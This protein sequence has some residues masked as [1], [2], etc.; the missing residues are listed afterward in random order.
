M[1]GSIQGKSMIPAIFKKTLSGVVI[2]SAI[3]VSG[4]VNAKQ[5]D[6]IVVGAGL[7]GLTAA[8]ELEQR[9]YNVVIL[10]AR[11]RVGGRMGTLDMG[12]QHGETGGELLD[13]K[14]VHTEMF[15]YAKK[16]K[17]EMVDVGYWENG[18]EEG[19]YYIDGK[20]I[21]YGDFK[22]E[23]GRPVKREMDRFWNAVEDLSLL[24]PDHTRPDLAPD[25]QILDQM[26]MQDWINDL[27]LHPTAKK[28]AE[29]HVRAEYD[30]PHDVSVL[31]MAHQSKVYENVGDNKIEVIRFMEGGRAFAQAYVDHIDGPVLLNHAVTKIRQND[32]GVVV[33]ASGSKF[34]ADVAVVTVPLTVLDKITFK[35]ALPANK[36]AAAENLNYGSHTKVLIEYSKRF[37]L[38]LNVGGD[39]VSDLP[40]GWTWESTERQVDTTGGILI[41]YSSG[42]FTDNQI[43]WSDAALIADKVAQIAIMYPGSAQYFESASVHAWHREE[44]I[45]G[46]FLAY[47]PGQVTQ[48][49][50]AFI[51]PAGKVYFAGEHT[52]DAYVGY[53]EGAVR[54]GMRVAKQIAGE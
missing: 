11:D 42:D 12:D 34:K 25:A 9:G 37:W 35:P 45:M 23:L 4:L 31:W 7:A 27:N 48:Y 53:L 2:S 29:H 18:V 19:A 51:E 21:P 28:L 24:I 49:W 30:E 52:D 39:T 1:L 43:N 15:R 8:Y 33:T 14:K 44:W 54:S 17:V 46:G 6:A 10:E 3:L 32:K 5:Q 22:S 26:N 16:F 38:D 41:A 13:S 36:Q 50:N 20:L 47:G 40:I